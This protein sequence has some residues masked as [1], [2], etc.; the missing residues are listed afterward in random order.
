MWSMNGHHMV[1]EWELVTM[2]MT[3][4]QYVVNLRPV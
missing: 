3:S 2:L 1:S 4:G